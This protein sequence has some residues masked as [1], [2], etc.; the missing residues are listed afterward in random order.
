MQPLQIKIMKGTNVMSTI[1]IG[2]AKR[3]AELYW[4]ICKQ[5]RDAGSEL[6]VETNR[7][8]LCQNT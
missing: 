1:G 5:L 6:T 8:E 2:D 3:G 7:K 4:Q